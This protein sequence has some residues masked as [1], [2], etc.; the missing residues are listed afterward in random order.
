MKNLFQET[1]ITPVAIVIPVH[2]DFIFFRIAVE[3]IIQNTLYPFKLII[4]ES[5]STDGSKEYA[6]LLPKFYPNLDI[7]IVHTKKEGPMKAYNLGFEISKPY[8]VYFTQT[9]TYHP[10][11]IGR[12][13]LH[14][15]V[16]LSRLPSAGLMTCIGGTGIAGAPYK[17]G[18]EWVGGWCMYVPR[19]ILDQL[20]GFDEN[21]IIGDGT[22]IEF[23]Y[24]IKQAGY[25]IYMA[26]FWIDHHRL[27][28]H[29]NE[30]IPDLEEIK[31][32][33]AEY[34]RKK[35]KLGEFVVV[36]R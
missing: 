30:I 29:S 1:E 18:F 6:D 3:S 19:K 33:N 12:D 8:D 20:G 24:R 14:E 26:G 22:D 11:L 28:A 36:D 9:D 32:K 35:Y 5:E 16:K 23:S 7:R 4:I 34:F 31:K 27:T 13:W 25:N 10:R 17:E 21:F 2:N 15:L